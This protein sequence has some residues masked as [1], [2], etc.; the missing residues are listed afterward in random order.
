M[1]VGDQLFK[2]VVWYYRYPTTETGKIANHLAFY[3][4]RVDAIFADG[5]EVPKP[6]RPPR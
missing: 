5:Q 4:E 6:Q 3:D 1:V 2:D